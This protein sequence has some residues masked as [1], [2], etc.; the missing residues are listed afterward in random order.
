MTHKQKISSKS[1]AQQ[2][3]VVAEFHAHRIPAQRIAFRTGVDIVLVQSLLEGVAHQA[4]F[5][6]LVA[7]HRRNRRDQRLKQS[8]RLK[9]IA[10]AS[11]QDTIEQEYQES[12]R[13]S[14]SQ[15]TLTKQ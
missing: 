5:K 14:A 15:A 13:V 7:R 3:D 4:R 10:Q 12:V 2:I 9:G 6:Y 8:L 11:L 1:L